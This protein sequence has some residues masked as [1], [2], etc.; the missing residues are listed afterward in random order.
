MSKR[1]TPSK[2]GGTPPSGD[3]STRDVAKDQAAGVAQDAVAGG[4]QTADT[5]K[6]QAGE[7]AA[8][9][10]SQARQLVDQTRQQ[11]A[12]QGQSQQQR[13]TTGL[14]SL[15]DELSGMANGEQGSG[16]ATD[17][18]RQ[19]SD[20][21]RTVAEYV[22]SRQPSDLLFEVRRFARQ[23]PG[24]FLLGALAA[25]FLGGRMTR[26]AVDEARDSSDGRSDYT[27]I[28]QQGYSDQ[29]YSGQG[30]SDQGY[31]GQGYESQGYSTPGYESQVYSGQT[32]GQTSSHTSTYGASGADYSDTST[33][34]LGESGY[35]DTQV[36]SA[37]GVTSSSVT[38]EYGGGL[39]STS[40]SLT[41][42]AGDPTAAFSP[43][44]PQTGRSEAGSSGAQI[45][46]P[47]GEDR[48]GGR[49]GKGG[50]I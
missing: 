19:A 27:G 5:A 23:R 6:Q 45:S 4:K 44:A 13:V 17:V 32:Q 46:D 31:S 49:T 28:P 41:N 24:T 2:P 16:I 50:P 39:A 15:A 1:S 11:I 48:V 34:G 47:A 8:E 42:P 14:R 21:V 30:Y 35:R 10:K 38:T 3:S 12:E 22:E 25:G 7:V 43:T 9:A 18:V 33:T 36:S 29:G 40:D 37:P 26:G 20:R